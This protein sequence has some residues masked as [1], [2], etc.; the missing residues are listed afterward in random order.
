MHV[1]SVGLLCIPTLSSSLLLSQSPV[2][3]VPS[4]QLWPLLHLMIS[5]S[6]VEIIGE[7]TCEFPT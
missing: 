2:R 5:S 7:A 3:P 1:A 4:V 6:A